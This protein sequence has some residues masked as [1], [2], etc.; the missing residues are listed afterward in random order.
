MISYL[1]V[2][3]DEDIVLDLN[4]NFDVATIKTLYPD[5]E[6]VYSIEFLKPE[7]Q[8]KYGEYI[9]IDP[10]TGEITIKPAESVVFADDVNLEMVEFIGIATTPKIK[11]ETN[12]IF[13]FNNN[14]LHAETLNADITLALTDINSIS[15]YLFWQTQI[16]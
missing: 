4:S 9:V 14:P 12:T 7:I 1:G 8:V 11:I 16:K 2:S 6:V 13:Y 5:D 10:A 15:F 3:M